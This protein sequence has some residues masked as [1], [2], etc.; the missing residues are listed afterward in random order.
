[1]LFH[2]FLTT[3]W[4]LIVLI[5]MFQYQSWFRVNQNWISAL[6]RWKPKISK[7]IKSAVNNVKPLK[8]RCSVLSISGTSTREN[9]QSIKKRLRF[10][11]R[12]CNKYC[13]TVDCMQ[14]NLEKTKKNTIISYTKWISCNYTDWK[15]NLP[16]THPWQQ[17]EIRFVAEPAPK[18]LKTIK[19]K[20]ENSQ[21]FIWRNLTAKFLC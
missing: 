9:I 10:F 11:Q 5:Y 19:L 17:S 20:G 13:H 4:Q 15:N 6:Q 2:H 21:D 7:I 14:F 1:M 12:R 8:Q 16:I 3:L 18:F